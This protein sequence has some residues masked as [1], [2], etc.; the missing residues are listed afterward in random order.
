ME[1]GHFQIKFGSEMVSLFVIY[2]IHN[3]SVL[4]S[5][6]E[7]VSIFEN[8]IKTI[9]NKLLLMGDLNIYIKRLDDPNTIIFNDLL[10]S[11]NLRNNISFQTHISAMH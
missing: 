8:S 1:C 4:K 6:E 7:M 5:C 9:R 3:T 10:D 11:L 2:H